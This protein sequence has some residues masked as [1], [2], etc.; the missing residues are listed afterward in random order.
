MSL[1]RVLFTSLALLTTLG[2]APAIAD[3][4]S[5]DFEVLHT[6]LCGGY[7]GD[8]G[9]VAATTLKATG[10]HSPPQ[11]TRPIGLM[12][13]EY[14]EPLKDL[15]SRN[16]GSVPLPKGLEC[17]PFK[18]VPRADLSSWLQQGGDW[19]TFRRLYPGLD[20]IR[21]VSLPGYN[22]A[23][24]RALVEVVVSCGDNCG[25]NQQFFAFHKVNGK[26]VRVGP[27]P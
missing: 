20:E 8:P 9:V 12:E 21:E 24:D 15:R 18:V 23:H 19:K 11:D 25:G 26:W 27:H 7:A 5:E 17:P 14:E 1:P 22:Q 13:D 6:L 4:E 10:A 2:L 16:S 3:T